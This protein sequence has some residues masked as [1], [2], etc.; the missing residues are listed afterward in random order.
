ML[1]NGDTIS[2]SMFNQIDKLSDKLNKAKPADP[3]ELIG[4]LCKS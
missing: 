4:P 1:G 3:F 2:S